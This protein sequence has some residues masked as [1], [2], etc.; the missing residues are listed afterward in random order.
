MSDLAQMARCTTRHLNRIF[1]DVVG[2]S[3]R[4]KNT[5]LRLARACELLATTQAK[6]VDVALESGYQSLSLFNSMFTRRFGVSPGKWR[7]NVRQ[8]KTA[9]SQHDWRKAPD[10]PVCNAFVTQVRNPMV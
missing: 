6:V 2:M 3:F 4:E 9:S 10:S 1:N 5:E 8:G 7:E